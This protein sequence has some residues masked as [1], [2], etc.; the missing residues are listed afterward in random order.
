V[1]EN[2]ELYYAYSL[3]FRGRVYRQTYLLNPSVGY[4]NKQLLGF[5]KVK[6]TKSYDVSGSGFQILSGL[7]CIPTL[8]VQ[9]GIMTYLGKTGDFYKNVAK[10]LTTDLNRDSIFNKILSEITRVGKLTKK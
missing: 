4:I 3:D 5:D 9:T 6:P 10:D 1:F 2:S 8:L 7:L